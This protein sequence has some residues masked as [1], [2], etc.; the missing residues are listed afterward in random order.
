MKNRTAG[1]AVSAT[2]LFLAVTAFGQGYD[3][4]SPRLIVTRTSHHYH[5]RYDNGPARLVIHRIPNLG[6]NVIVDLWI[7][8]VAAGPIGYGH[9][10]T[11]EIPAGRHV[12]SL[13][14]TPA[15]TWHTST[16][17]PVDLQSGGT[18]HF[19]ARPDHSGHVTL[20]GGGS[21]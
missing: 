8:G 9:R 7:D 13:L 2:I 16:E 6:A 10:Y 5:H 3:T 18:Y 4:E 11:A 19:T 20:S 14:P 15:P 21:L 17:I 12:L 1:F